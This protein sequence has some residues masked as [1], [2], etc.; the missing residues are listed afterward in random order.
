MI[1]IWSPLTVTC[2]AASGFW[3]GPDTGLPSSTEKWLLWQ[4][5]TI[6]PS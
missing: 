3:A 2:L 4:G 1:E 5:Q 6:S